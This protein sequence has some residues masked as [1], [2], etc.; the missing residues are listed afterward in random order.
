VTFKVLENVIES[1]PLPLSVATPTTNSNIDSTLN[2]DSFDA[3]KILMFA[4]FVMINF[5]FIVEFKW[6]AILPISMNLN[7]LVISLATFKILNQ[8][9]NMSLIYGVFIGVII[10]NIVMY[11]IMK[12]FM[13]HEGSRSSMK[14]RS[15]KFREQFRNLFFTIIILTGAIQLFDTQFT[16]GVDMGL[17]VFMIASVLSLWTVYRTLFNEL[18]LIGR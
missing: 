2:I 4:V 1:E 13:T 3:I 16:L 5:A 12:N 6:G 17:G 18:F 10:L 9:L 8:I 7:S 11:I 14:D 15:A